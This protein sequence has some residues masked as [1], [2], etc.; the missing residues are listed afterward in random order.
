MGGVDA[1]AADG[2]GEANWEINCG[3]AQ[4]F[5]I[6]TGNRIATK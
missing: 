6:P 2:T 3:M 4:A 1:T 5:E